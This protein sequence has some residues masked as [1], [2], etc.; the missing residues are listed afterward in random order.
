M[1]SPRDY[2]GVR[3]PLPASFEAPQIGLQLGD[4]IAD[5]PKRFEQGQQY[6][7]AQALRSAFPSGLPMRPDGT[8]DASAVMNKIVSIGGLD[9]SSVGP[10]LNLAARQSLQ[11]GDQP[12]YAAGAPSGDT[13]GLRGP[14]ASGPIASND[15]TGDV[16]TIRGIATEAFG[17]RDVREA[18]P[19]YAAALRVGI[20]DPLN[21]AQV[22]RARRIMGGVSASEMNQP[23]RETYAQ[24]YAYSGDA[25]SNTTVSGTG[26][27]PAGLESPTAPASASS[28]MQATG[29]SPVQ[30]R[31]S[32]FAR[33]G[34]PT[35]MAEPPAGGGNMQQRPQVAQAQQPGGL[36]GTNLVPAGV[37]MTPLQY[38]NWLMQRAQQH[39]MAGDKEGADLFQK[40]A[41]PIFDALKD[42]GAL[43]TEQKNAR[44]SGMTPLQFEQAKSL[45]GEDVKLYSKLYAGISA[46]GNTAAQSLPQLQAAR[47]IVQS[48]DFYS[49]LW[50]P[51]NLYVKQ[52]KAM[53][54]LDP[55]AAMTQEAFTKTMSSFVLKQTDDLRA[56]ALEQ[57]GSSGRIFAQQIELMVKAAPSTEHSIAGNR[58]L[59]EIYSRA[60]QRAMQM[61]DMAARYN[62][63][64]LDA[65]FEAQMRRWMVDNPMFTKDEIADP[66][67][68]AAPVFNHINDARAAGV[69]KGTVVRTPSGNYG[70]MP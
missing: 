41:Q 25:G 19:R 65:N 34:A 66:R 42:A 27:G 8:L 56:Q 2:E 60:A 4:R 40:Q 52:F 49:G 45:Q 47:S 14:Q 22:V 58:Y 57:A 13:A 63:G 67:L 70:V 44:T 17:G 59:V 62:N 68:V 5:L 7:V 26:G 37:R 55:N 24:D 9:S 11:A 18:L 28:P 54:G 29:V 50:Q 51:G 15:Q 61:A 23:A 31:P 10:L 1:V 53:V 32:P 43:T 30:P 21:P 20:D 36:P 69:K 16:D 35:Q 64:H 48:K 12:P 6:Q 38:G 33:G 46:M 39:A 3:A